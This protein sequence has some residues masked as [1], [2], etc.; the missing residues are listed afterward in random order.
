M[1]KRRLGI[2]KYFI[3]NIIHDS[4]ILPGI[5]NLAARFSVDHTAPT[6]IRF[7]DQS[8]EG[9]W[10]EEI[11]MDQVHI[12]ENCKREEKILSADSDESSLP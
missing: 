7:C 2:L 11:E 6:P 1:T 5:G 3:D 10:G 8:F 12:S 4:I 9:I